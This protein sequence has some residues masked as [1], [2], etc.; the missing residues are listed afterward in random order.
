MIR[1]KGGG[2][3][4]KK[5][6]HVDVTY[7]P[8]PLMLNLLNLYQISDLA[9]SY[10]YEV[11]PHRQWCYEITFVIEGEGVF[12]R[13]D[14]EYAVSPGKLFVVSKDDTHYIRSSKLRPLRYISVGFTFNKNHTDYPKYAAVADFFDNAEEPIADDLY[15]TYELLSAALSEISSPQTLSEEMV[16]NYLLLVIVNAYRSFHSSRRTRHTDLV[17][18]QNTNPLIYEMIRYIDEHLT[19]M[20]VLQE[21]SHALGYSY[22]YL[23]RLFSGTMGSTLRQYYNERRFEKA[24]EL[25]AEPRPLADVAEQLG[26]TDTANF[27]RAFKKQ[28]QVSPGEYRR[29][30]KQ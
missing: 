10:D 22:S 28:Y 7:M 13:N 15:N 2:N 11:L 23:S 27:C 30:N 21:M 14:A 29:R 12:R 24:R 9:C 6:Y 26:F 8:S 16:A 19:S 1:C 18:P 20:T 3:V 25:L 17:T 4:E 5:R